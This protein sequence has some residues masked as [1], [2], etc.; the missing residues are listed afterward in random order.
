MFK[1]IVNGKNGKEESEFAT[2]E[3][4][5][6]HFDY[7][8]ALGY[9]GKEE[10]IIEHETIPAVIIEHPEVLA[11]T[12]VVS[13]EIPAVIIEHPEVPEVLA[14]EQVINELGE[15]VSPARESSPAVPA[16]TEVVSEAVPAVIIEH[17]YIPAWTEVVSEEVPAWTEVIP[18]EYTWEIVEFKPAIA[19]VSPR[20][21]RLALLSIGV[22]EEMIDGAIA[23]MPS[24]D[25]EAAMIAWKYS[26]YYERSIPIIESMGVALGLTSEQLD[27]LWLGA[28]TL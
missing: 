27:A 17:P 19:P 28:A 6:A 10:Q 21:I 15:I 3:D 8:R 11:W 14:Q 1:L 26:G 25:K 2:R 5:Q 13:E 20:Q 4:A 24:P 9:W 7:H 16:W 23:Q 18:V 22:T 12:E